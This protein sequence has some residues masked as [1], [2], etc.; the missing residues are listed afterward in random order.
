[1]EVIGNI[2]DYANVEQ[3][4][5]TIN[6]DYVSLVSI[7]N[8]I[9]GRFKE[10]AENKDLF[11][12]FERDTQAPQGIIS[13]EHRIQQIL[14]YL[15]NNSVK[16]TERGGVDVSIGVRNQSSG[17][18]QLVMTVIDTGIGI[19]EDTIERVF[20]PFEQGDASFSKRYGGLG[21][22][23]S[24]TR[25]IVNTMGGDIKIC[26]AESQ[27][28][29]VTVTLPIELAPSIPSVAPVAQR[30]NEKIKILVAEDNLVNQILLNNILEKSEYDFHLVEDGQLAV[31]EYKT[32]E[33]HV[34]LMDIQMP[35]M[36]GIEATRIIREYEI[37]NQLSPIPIIALTASVTESDQRKVKDA[38][39]NYF[40]PK[41]IDVQQLF[42]LVEQSLLKVAA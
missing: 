17:Q 19:N 5:V 37:S 20:I 14:S 15:I 39:M 32:G 40:C 23:L 35:V 25:I 42:S 31:E 24:I 21:L 9:T 3:E 28:T 41:P 7:Q 2:L 8:A 10:S 4:K 30:S 26:R 33:Y 16:F 11:L 22:G 1:M 36:S 6:N 38:G 12:H 13:D 27:G 18:N 34:I 29:K